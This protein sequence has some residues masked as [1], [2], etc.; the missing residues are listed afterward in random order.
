MRV[1]VFG[2]NELDHL[3]TRL[4]D[5]R[6]RLYG[7]IGAPMTLRYA[8]SR[9]ERADARRAFGRT[10]LWICLAGAAVTLV[11]D[12]GRHFFLVSVAWL[13]CVFAPIRIAVE[14]L[15][16]AG[17]RWR[18]SLQ[19]RLLE[20]P[21]RYTS[22]EDIALMVEWFVALDVR[23][24]RLASRD[25]APKVIA[26]AAR[27][28]GATLRDGAPSLR[29]AA[30]RCASLLD[31]WLAVIAA[32]ER[33]LPL[34]AA[35]QTGPAAGNGAGSGA[36]WDPTASIQDQWTTLR[37]IA[38]LAALTRVLV[39][40]YEDNTGLALE[41]AAAIRTEADAAMDYVDQVGLRL[42]GPPWEDVSGVPPASLPIETASRVAEAWTEFFA[43]PI[44]APR[45][46]AAFVS[47]V[48]A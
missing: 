48:T 11:A 14:V 32:G 41:G 7:T 25:L 10:W 18:A 35:A 30:I 46:L 47:A 3:K 15:Q 21:D 27:L 13:V 19:R 5:G 36:L 33:L 1:G 37:A 4:G 8:L 6:H 12:G 44:P 39:D 28:C 22:P 17:P 40:V 29:R 31:R 20:R 24:P 2:E 9:L 23:A 34:P 43:H 45:R 42:D 16:T 26:A 38:G